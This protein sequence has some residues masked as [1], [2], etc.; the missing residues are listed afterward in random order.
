MKNYLII[1]AAAL[2]LLAACAKVTPVETSGSAVSFTVTNKL[3]STK[4]DFVPG[5][6]GFDA[7]HTYAIL[8][9]TD[10]ANPQQ[11]FMEN[12]EVRAKAG[13][14]DYLWAPETPYYWPKTSPVSF[15]SY[16]GTRV[17]DVYPTPTDFTKMVFGSLTPASEEKTLVI[18]GIPEFDGESAEGKE[19]EL[20]PADN[21]LVA[22][23]DHQFF[24]AGEVPVQF[25]HMLAK[26]RFQL[27]LDASANQESE[28][29]WSL[30]VPGQQM[31]TVPNAG[32]LEVTYPAM[33]EDYWNETPALTEYDENGNVT[34]QGIKWTLLTGD[35]YLQPVLAPEMTVDAQGG[36]VVPDPEVEDADNLIMV[37]SDA[38]GKPLCVRECVVIP[39][40]YGQRGF[41]LEFQLANEYAGEKGLAENLLVEG[42]M[43]MFVKDADPNTLSWEANHIYTYRI[44][45]KTN[46]QI[47][48]DPAVEEWEETTPG[49]N[50]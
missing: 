36:F 2:L 5:V 11:W 48:F 38:D 33:N 6:D 32:M 47:T 19:P 8:H 45:V 20:L 13:S 34:F 26:I 35:D 39:Q 14:S 7:F 49:L 4:A 28:T 31:L 25:R 15:F 21:I 17:P 12:V 43:S 16:A 41:R 50:L 10:P 23:P 18:R 3:A 1:S 30:Y 9:S 29:K 37:P 24:D 22:D 27:V 42:P 40:A 44:T 46:G